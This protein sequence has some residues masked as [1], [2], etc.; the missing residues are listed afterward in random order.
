MKEDIVTV[1]EGYFEQ[2][3]RTSM[4]RAAR[5]RSAR[6]SVLYSCLAVILLAGTALSVHFIGIAEARKEYMALQQEIMELDVFM[7]IN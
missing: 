3:Y 4:E 7:E 5:I 2:S 1:P 6:R